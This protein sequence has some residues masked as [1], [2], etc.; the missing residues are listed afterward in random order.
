MKYHILTFALIILN[1]SS[2]GQTKKDLNINY[3]L[4]GQI[5]AKSS[6]EDSTAAG[7]FGTSDNFAKQI[8]DSLIFSETGIF[9]KID[10]AKTITIADKFNAYNLYLGNKSDTILRLEASDSRLSVVAEAFYKNEW[11]P[12]EYLPSSWCGNSYH[13]IY[14][15]TNQF[16]IFVI[17]KFTG[18][19][20]TK[21][22][23]RL[24]ISK[25]HYIYSNEISTSINKGQLSA[26][27]GHKSQGLMD[28]Y[29]D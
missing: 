6:I 7:G 27:Q 4:R 9:L 11:K 1:L 10:T 2:F 15:K 8:N 21:I 17:P 20:K 24:A 13:N 3:K 14:I 5:Y 16:W 28:P 22:R 19:I 26:K 29:I 25:G 12:I 23:Y 18:K